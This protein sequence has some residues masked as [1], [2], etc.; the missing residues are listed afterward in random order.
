[1]ARSDVDAF[2]TA[3]P[4]GWRRDS[5]VAMLHDI[6]GLPIPL[7]ESL[8]WRNP[9]FEHHGAVVKWYLATEWINVYFFKGY[10]LE[11]PDGC[12]EPTSNSRMRTI[13][14]SETTAMNRSAFTALLRSAVEL[15]SPTGTTHTADL[16]LTEPEWPQ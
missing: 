14:I 1:M 10:L 6:R 8:K 11:D 9:Y 2:I 3:L 7:A 4:A 5:C 16:R 12:F 13:K 15:N